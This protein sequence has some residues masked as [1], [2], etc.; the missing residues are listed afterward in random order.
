M[1]KRSANAGFP[2]SSNFLLPSLNV[3]KKTPTRSALGT[4]SP[5][6]VESRAIR[7]DPWIEYAGG[8]NGLTAGSGELERDRSGV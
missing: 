7:L 6:S 3:C 1:G 8:T 4:S 5:C 2:V